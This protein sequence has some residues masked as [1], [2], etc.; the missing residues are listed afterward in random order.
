[1]GKAARHPLH[2]RDFQQTDA[3]YQEESKS[4]RSQRNW[5]PLHS[6]GSD[7]ENWLVNPATPFCVRLMYRSNRLRHER[8]HAPYVPLLY[9][10][11]RVSKSRMDVSKQPM[12]VV[13]GHVEIM[14]VFG[15]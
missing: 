6:C 1:M 3:V 11:Y 12:M 4:G 7:F 10:C 13:A 9:I 5:T 14:V 2:T 8:G 15:R